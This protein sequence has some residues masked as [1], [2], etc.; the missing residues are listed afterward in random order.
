[1]KGK[2]YRGRK[3]R[4]MLND[5]TFYI[6]M[7]VFVFAFFC[8]DDVFSFCRFSQLFLKLLYCLD[9][10]IVSGQLALLR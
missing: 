5:L 3:R 1:M 7:F 8:T 6:N 10:C 4:H 9:V 2:T